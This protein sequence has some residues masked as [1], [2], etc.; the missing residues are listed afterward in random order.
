MGII[1]WGRLSSTMSHT[2]NFLE[3]K[4]VVPTSIAPI[5]F[6]LRETSFWLIELK[7]GV[8][9]EILVNL[10]YIAQDIYR[11]LLKNGASFFM[12]ITDGVGHLKSEV[13]MGLWEL[14]TAGLT[15]ADLFDNLRS[16]IDP[17]RRLI[18]R[19]RRVVRH[20]YSSGR[21][22][23]LKKSLHS[24]N[25]EQIEATCWILLKRYGVVFRDLLAREK[26][27]PR[28]RELHT[29]FRRLEERGEIRGGRFIEGFL[30]EQFALPYAVESLRVIKNKEL[31]TEQISIAAVDPLNLSGF[32]LPGPRVAAVSGGTVFLNTLLKS[33]FPPE[34]LSD[35]S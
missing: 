7:E 13:E 27:I 22:S 5:T 10:S 24:F 25:N 9:E 23:L 20:Q 4:R 30:G 8:K 29:V 32:I 2:D 21:W 19:K 1:G 16:L 15:T 11:Y 26:N 17:R 33:S 6:F 34:K 14:V 12:D 35:D 28:W 3:N 31:S 18:K